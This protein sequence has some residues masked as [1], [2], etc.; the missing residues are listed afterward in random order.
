MKTIG[1]IGG[2]SWEST[3]TYYK[4]I[5]SIIKDK[6]GGLN[7]AKIVLYSVNFKEIED[8]QSIGDWDKSGAILTDSAKKL[9][10]AGADFIL[11]CTNTMHKVAPQ[12]ASAISVPLLHIAD[13]TADALKSKNIS[14]V[15]LLGTKYTMEQDFYKSRLL[16][17]GIDVLIPSEKDRL[18]IN[19]IIFKEL[20][21]GK[22]S[23]ESKKKFI[24]IIHGLADLG[25]SGAVLGCTEIGMLINQNDTK[26][27]IFDTAE[28]HAQ[29]AANLALE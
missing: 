18:I 12:V 20:C 29:A 1:L 4:I 6:L 16:S 11:I 7:S 13:V 24:E 3:A 9:E 5:N 23:E 17:K 27:P 21:V 19:N 8:C 14:K 26:I 25:A 22:I 15:A 28:I 2:M 10:V